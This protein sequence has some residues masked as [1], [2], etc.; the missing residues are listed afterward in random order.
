M[1]LSANKI[2]ILLLTYL[3][4]A[5]CYA[6]D[7]Y[8]PPANTYPAGQPVAQNAQNSNEVANVTPD[9]PP[10]TGKCVVSG[11]GTAS[12]PQY[13]F[14]VQTPVLYFVCTSPDVKRGQSFKG[15]WIAVNTR[16]IMPDNTVLSSSVK[17]VDVDATADK[18]WV[19]RF[20]VAMPPK[21]W[22]VGTY[23]IDLYYNNEILT[24]HNLTVTFN[25]NAW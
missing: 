23:M 13:R 20:Q 10:P 21:G 1:K 6:A 25:V 15:V 24:S 19:A 17:T 18:P 12:Q 22:P 4:A 7:T 2:V 11:S 14:P 5:A 16:G 3:T 8:A 9:L